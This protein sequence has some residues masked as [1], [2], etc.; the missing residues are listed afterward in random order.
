MHA[1]RV[2]PG[3][4]ASAALLTS[5]ASTRQTVTSTTTVAVSNT[6]T[7]G[8]TTA[9]PP[10][11]AAT[12]AAIT[13]ASIPTLNTTITTAAPTTTAPTSTTTSAPATTAATLAQ[14]AIWPAASVVFTTPQE[15]AADFV[16]TVLHVAPVLGTYQGG[17]ARSG[18]IEVFSPG[19]SA[20]VSRSVLLLR[21]LAPSNGWFVIG[22]A[23]AHETISSPETNATV[24]AGK[25]T[26]KGV[27]RGFEAT[28][29]VTAFLA[30]HADKVFERVITS[31][32]AF[33]TAQPYSVT[34]D[35][36]TALPGS[37]ITLLVRGDT[38]LETD[39]GE[40]GAIPVVI[41]A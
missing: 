35:L 1:I 26:V 38:G 20:P 40:F 31:G 2:L 9:A 18:E 24:A 15:A 12:T 27:A 13:T 7:A 10:T 29:V 33:E 19:E 6:T 14:P 25:L 23:N 17:D 36:T 30:G 34:V 22:A 11:A 37:V 41:G 16:R 32:G 28:V 8:P 39:P 21:Q 3:L 4:I 5:C